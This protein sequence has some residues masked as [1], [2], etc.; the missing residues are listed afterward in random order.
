M[1]FSE[2]DFK[3]SIAAT[4]ASSSG[5]SCSPGFSSDR[6]RTILVS[7]FRGGEELG[8][9]I[10][11]VFVIVVSGVVCTLSDFWASSNDR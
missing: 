2:P 6:T 1:I 5:T 4:A 3:E 11:T 8:E 7:D 9:T 10:A